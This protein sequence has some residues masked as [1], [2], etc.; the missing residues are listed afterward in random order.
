MAPSARLRL[1]S[2]EDR[3]TPSAYGQLPLAFE[4]NQGQAVAP[5]DF[6]AR[7]DGYAL[8]LGPT[9]ATL[10][11][12]GPAGDAAVRLPSSGPTRWPR[13]SAADELVT[14]TNYFLGSDPSQWRTERPQLRQGRVRGRLPRH[15]P[16]LL[17]QPAAARVRLRRRARR[18]PAAHP[19]VRSGAPRACGSTRQGDLVLHTAG[20]DVVQHAPV[21]YQEVDGVRRPVAGRF[22]LARDRGRLPRRARTTRPRRWSSTRS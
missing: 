5:A 2:L 12:R 19:A 11:L 17:R 9:G 20:G 10:G 22:V 14:K 8:A 16:R 1:V 4:A 7:G 3:A 21:I 18:R 13:P 15:R 6:L